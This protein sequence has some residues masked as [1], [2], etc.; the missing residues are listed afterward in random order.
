MPVAQFPGRRNW[1]Y[2]GVFTYAAQNS[3]GGARELQRFVDVCHHKGLAVIL[4]VVYNHLGPEGNVLAEFAPYFNDLYRTPWGPAL[5][6][7]S[8]GSDDVRDYFWLNARQW[9]EDFHIDALRL[10]A[11]HAILDTS[12]T[13]FIAELS[14][15]SHDL[16]QELARRCDLIAESASNDPRVV[17]PLTSGGLGRR[18][19]VERRFSPRAP[20]LAHGRALGVLRGLRRAERLGA[21]DERRIR[22]AGRVFDL[23]RSSPRCAVRLDT[24][25]AIRRLRPEPRSGG[26]SCAR[27]ATGRHWWAPSGPRSLPRSSALS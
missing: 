13:P 22:T 7:D 17:T 20:R 23:S 18:R 19:A 12:A 5:N 2:D 10:D 21:S 27:R 11:V 25:R 15:R 9:F 24:A 3:Y 26:K 4:D 6:F 16:G 1:G 8:A 14:Q